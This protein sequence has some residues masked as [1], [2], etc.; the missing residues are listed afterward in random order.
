MV[1]HEKARLLV[2]GFGVFPSSKPSDI[3]VAYM[4]CVC[5]HIQ[6]ITVRP[7]GGISKGHDAQ[8]IALRLI[9]YILRTIVF[10]VVEE[11]PD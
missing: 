1:R 2:T 10:K 8:Q 4:E 5:T 7:L 6:E 3:S 9:S 11:T